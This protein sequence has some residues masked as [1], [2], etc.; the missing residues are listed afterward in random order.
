MLN[1][2]INHINNKEHC[3]IFLIILVKKVIKGYHLS[4]L[5]DL[6]K[7]DMNLDK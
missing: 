5:Y 2:K 7:F 1:L 3:A 4:C 6:I